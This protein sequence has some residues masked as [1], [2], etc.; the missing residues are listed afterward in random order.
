LKET[1]F[2]I[3]GYENNG[4]LNGSIILNNSSLTNRTLSIQ[5]GSY[6]DENAIKIGRNLA[7]QH[8]ISFAND[9]AGSSS[10]WISF[11]IWNNQDQRNTVLTLQS[12]FGSQFGIATIT[13]KLQVN[14]GDFI[15]QGEM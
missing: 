13:G 8:Y 7:T 1:Q 11:K 5:H 12:L 4:G 14:N 10:N 6:N 2:K 9:T 15:T 3:E